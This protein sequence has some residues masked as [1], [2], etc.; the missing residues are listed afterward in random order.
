[1]YKMARYVTY[2]GK[3]SPGNPAN[4]A[5]VRH[6]ISWLDMLNR[7]D[8]AHH[9]FPEYK[10]TN[11]KHV[12]R[13]KNKWSSMC[14]AGS[15]WRRRY[16]PRQF[17]TD[18]TETTAYCRERA[19][20]E[21]DEAQRAQT[22]EEISES[23]EGYLLGKTMFASQPRIVPEVREKAAMQQVFE[24]QATLDSGKRLETCQK[25]FLAEVKACSEAVRQQEISTSI[26]LVARAAVTQ[27]MLTAMQASRG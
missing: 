7:D 14:K 8:I 18:T 13:I 23:I 12:K 10:A 17:E 6:K 5:R 1:M 21:R 15:K 26:S 11:E 20:F 25:K 22:H 4:F 3:R 19:I 2:D 16:K 27:V 9:T 24:L